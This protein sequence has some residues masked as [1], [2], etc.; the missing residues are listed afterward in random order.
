MSRWI[1]I[2]TLEARPDLERAIYEVALETLPDVPGEAP[3]VPGSFEEFL[4]RDVTKPTIPAWGF[5]IAVESATGR[6]V[7]YASLEIPS[8][9]PLL[10]WHYMTGVTRAW[11][12]RGVASAMKRATI[13][14]AVDHGLDALEGENDVENAPMR[15]INRRLGYEPR[16]DQIVLR[17]PLAP[18]VT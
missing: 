18:V 3:Q 14:A 1:E 6:P 9:T 12:G 10:A 5:A 8:G 13:R 16:P 2:T 15:A 11:R 4:A 7:G 17:G